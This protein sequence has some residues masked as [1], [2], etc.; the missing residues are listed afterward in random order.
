MTDRYLSLTQLADYSSLSVRLLKKYL[1]DPDHPLKSHLL[2]RRRLVKVSDFDAWLEE[3]GRRAAPVDPR[4]R[5]MQ[6]KVDATVA[7]IRSSREG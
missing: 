5:E 3:T 2:G 7:S 4:E 1:A 6:R